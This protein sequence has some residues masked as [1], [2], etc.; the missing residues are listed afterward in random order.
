MAGASAVQVGTATF[1]D[2]RASLDV[3]GGIGSFMQENRVKA[4]VDI[5]GQSLI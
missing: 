1:L 3:I 2:P 5:V 4:L